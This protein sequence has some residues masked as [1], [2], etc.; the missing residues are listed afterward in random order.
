MIIFLRILI[1]ASKVSKPEFLARVWEW[2]GIG[3]D[4]PAV[5]AGEEV[6]L[7]V[8]AVDASDTG[9]VVVRRYLQQ[10]ISWMNALIYIYWQ[11]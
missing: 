9:A 6:V 2:R 3:T 11:Q 10:R 5:P 7:V 1:P 8:E 4:C